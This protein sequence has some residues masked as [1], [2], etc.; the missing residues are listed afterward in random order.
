[1]ELH[2]RYIAFR[3]VRG[4]KPAEA[5]GGRAACS[6]KEVETDCRQGYEV[7]SR[8]T[9]STMVLVRGELINDGCPEH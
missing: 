2:R 1:V 4:P 7:K 3:D 9:C 6:A 5:N 8:K